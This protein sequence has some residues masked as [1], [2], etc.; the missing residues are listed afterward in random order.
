MW[1]LVSVCLEIVSV[2][3]PDRCTVLPNVPYAQ[4]LFWTHPMLLLGNVGHVE[5]YFGL[6]VDS[7]YIDAR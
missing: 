7:V 3:V 2:S 4:K 1:N 6:F 5:S